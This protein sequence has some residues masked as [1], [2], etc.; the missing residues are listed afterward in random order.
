MNK[1]PRSDSVRTEGGVSACWM[2]SL[3]SSS[4]S[5]GLMTAVATTPDRLFETSCH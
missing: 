5:T 4:S 1:N 2:S 3:C